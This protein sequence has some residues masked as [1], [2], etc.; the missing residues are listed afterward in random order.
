MSAYIVSQ[1]NFDF[2]PLRA[3]FLTEQILGP[4][5]GTF[6][7]LLWS[8]T[9]KRHDTVK[10]SPGKAHLRHVL[11]RIASVKS[12]KNACAVVSVTRRASPHISSI[13][14]VLHFKLIRF[15]RTIAVVF[16]SA[17]LCQRGSLRQRRVRLS[18]RL[19]VWTSVCHTPVLCLAE[20]K[21][22]REVY[23]V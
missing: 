12:F 18:V 2:F 11:C 20:R 3:R 4:Y 13:S 9:G 6:G 19:S 15:S 17:T 14:E 8:I 1:R 7:Q 5:F 22:D 16:T 23:T 21:Q 10:R